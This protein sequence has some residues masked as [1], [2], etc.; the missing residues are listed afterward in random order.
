[1]ISKLRFNLIISLINVFFLSYYVIFFD[2]T[3]D[4][5]F[6]QT[7]LVILV[8]SIISIFTQNIRIKLF[9]IFNNFQI[10]IFAL[11]I[12]LLLL[13]IGVFLKIK[14]LPS[15][16]LIYLKKNYST[17]LS[18]EKIITRM[19]KS[20]Y[21]KFK[22]NTKISTS[23]NWRGGPDQFEY[24][25]VSDDKGFKNL[26]KNEN[27]NNVDLVAFGDSFTEGMGV[28]TANTWTSLL[29]EKGISTYNFG[30]QGY[31]PTQILGTYQMYKS[32]IRNKDIILG[33]TLGTYK[34]EK[35]FDKDSE[36]YKKRFTG[37]I[38]NILVNDELKK[39][40][41]FV[42]SAVWIS[43]KDFRI[44]L[45]QFIANLNT[46]NIKVLDKKL[47]P[48]KSQISNFESEKMVNS[49][50]ES[51]E[52]KNTIKNFNKLN[53]LVK[54]N[55]SKLVII[56]FPSRDIVYYERISGKKLPLNFQ[57]KLEIEA[58]KDFSE[59]NNILFMNPT[60]YLIQYTNNLDKGFSIKDLPYLEIDGHLSKKG[61]E[62]IAQFILSS[63]K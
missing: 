27:L 4:G 1:M 10:S 60:N 5:I 49:F 11:I 2:L 53:I 51:L 28:K 35:F 29:S 38:Q 56:V 62:L 45:R 42:L 15:N 34:R 22:K 41:N 58:L 21:V 46:E 18:E 36:F 44:S 25:W 13:E 14:V 32:S 59:Q 43:L 16:I 7:F 12:F 19:D 8:F 20:P 26:K 37:G 9:R 3:R 23:G 17:E 48:Y 39:K 57:K 52:W 33:Y 40:T 30:V 61:H 55:D 6:Y 54:N 63:L 31:S 24:S 47:K 50:K